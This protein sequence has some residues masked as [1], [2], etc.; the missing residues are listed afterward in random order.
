MRTVLALLI[1]AFA[2]SCAVWLGSVYEGDSAPAGDGGPAGNVL[3]G[4]EST[5]ASWQNPLAVLV[6][7][8]GGAIAIALLVGEHRPGS[9]RRDEPS[10]D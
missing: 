9:R 10:P 5:K 3:V 8:T 4:E 2:L 6:G 1:A 7:A